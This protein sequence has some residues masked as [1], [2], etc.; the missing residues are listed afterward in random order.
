MLKF[1]MEITLL[2]LY[3]TVGQVSFILL[4]YMAQNKTLSIQYYLYC[5]S[6]SYMFTEAEL[7]HVLRVSCRGLTVQELFVLLIAYN[8]AVIYNVPCSMKHACVRI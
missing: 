3:F 2:I 1:E 6:G 7:G 5:P 8:Q 4:K